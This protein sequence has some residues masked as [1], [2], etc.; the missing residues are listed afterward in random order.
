MKEI[1]QIWNGF[2]ICGDGIVDVGGYCVGYCV[3]TF[4]A[5]F[6]NLRE[7]FESMVLNGNTLSTK[8]TTPQDKYTSGVRG[9]KPWWQRLVREKPK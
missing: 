1:A 4:H 6:V 2:V 8:K 3:T 7:I 5:R 9:L